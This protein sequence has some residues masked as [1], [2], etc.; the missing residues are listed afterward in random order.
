MKSNKD[1]FQVFFNTEETV[2]EN[3]CIA[4][5]INTTCQKLLLVRLDSKINFDDYKLAAY[6][7]ELTQNR[8]L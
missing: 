2:Q 6:A 4:Q 8:M 5:I 7:R 1:K 3:T